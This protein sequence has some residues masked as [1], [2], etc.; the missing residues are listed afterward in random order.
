M[1]KFD[2]QINEYI[3]VKNEFFDAKLKQLKFKIAGTRRPRLTLKHLN[4]LRKMRQLRDIENQ[5]RKLSLPAI[6]GDPDDKDD[7]NKGDET[8]LDSSKP[9]L[10]SIKA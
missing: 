2:V 3:S 9:A 4:K 8:E 7:S 1:G 10:R 5:Q 6:Y